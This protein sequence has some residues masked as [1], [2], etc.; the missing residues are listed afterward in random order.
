MG[1]VE[2]IECERKGAQEVTV[3]VGNEL[4]RAFVY[5]E[6]LGSLSVGDSVT[7]NTWAVQL[8]LGTGGY[9]FVISAPHK[10]TRNLAAGHILKLRYTPMQLPVLSAESPESPFHDE[11]AS[12]VSLEGMPVVC[13]ELH[14]Q[15]PAIASAIK[16]ETDGKARVGYVMTD[17]AALPLAFSK[18]VPLMQS[19][20]IVDFT[21][22]SGQSFG[23][24]FEAINVYTALA[25]AKVVGKADVIIVCQGPGNAGTGTPLGFSGIDQGIALNAAAA[26]DATAIATARISFADSRERHY[27]LSHHTRTVLERV[28]INSA[29]VP[30]PRL[31]AEKHEILRRTIVDTELED[32]HQFVTVDSNHGFDAFVASGFQ[33]TTMGRSISQDPEFFHSSVASG[34]LAGQLFN[35]DLQNL[36]G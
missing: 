9:D 11:I 3:R 28:A 12:F 24:D 36:S 35:C 27:G 26:L 20:K 13:A 21:V 7:L 1:V 19:A 6:L 4:R 14:S 23:G 29:I 10:D 17:G 18:L 32:R 5:T 16:W 34:L 33:V 22:T 31:A 2:S 30:I 15:V 8:G 25:L